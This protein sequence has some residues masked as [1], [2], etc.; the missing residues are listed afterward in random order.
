MDAEAYAEKHAVGKLL[1]LMSVELLSKRPQSPLSFL[2]ELC[3]KTSAMKHVNGVSPAAII[4]ETLESAVL[5]VMGTPAAG[6]K[7]ER[8]NAA[9]YFAP[10]RK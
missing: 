3:R 1:Q 6:G 2:E 7:G 4:S 9:C 8:G 10:N 5:E